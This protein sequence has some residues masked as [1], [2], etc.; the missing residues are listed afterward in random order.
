MNPWRELFARNETLVLFIHGQ[1]FFVLG[2]VILWQSRQHSRLDLARNLG[3]LGLFGIAHGLY[4]WGDV[5][6]PIQASYLSRTGVETLL[7][8]QAVLLA[9]SFA[10][11]FQFGVAALGDLHPNWRW[12][13][14]LPG[15][16]LVT[17]MSAFLWTSQVSR[18][19]ATEL[20]V[21]ANVWARYLLGVTGAI[22][23][24][25]GLRAQARQPMAVPEFSSLSRAFQVA[26][27]ALVSYAVLGGLVVPPAPFFPASMLNTDTVLNVLGVPV[28]VL[29]S[30]VGLVLVVSI[31]RGL[32]VFR[33]EADRRME[34]MEQTQ[35]LMVERERISRE[36]HDGAIQTVYTAGLIAESVRKRLPDADPLAVRLDSVVSALSHAIHDLRHLISN[37]EPKTTSSDLAAELR[38]L[39]EDSHVNWLIHVEVSLIPSDGALL[40]PNGANHVRAIVNEALS[41]I[42]RHARARHAWIV[43]E[44][45]NGELTITVAD[46]GDGVPAQHTVGFGLRNMRDRARLLGGTLRVDPRAPRGTQVI[47]TIPW[48]G[49]P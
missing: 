38:Q 19:S 13:E 20:I 33:M 31:A 21:S 45:S 3:W 14:T 40:L 12:I 10:M 29:R 37:L 5:F 1:V 43:A 26:S 11:L 46:D 4:V 35:I 49:T 27:L 17:W 34:E 24:A 8:V 42:A 7:M 36:L 32:E 15:L 28:Q 9:F 48:D 30:V 25:I 44:R 2:L 16:L 41:N 47:L 39:A 23:A 22:V 6:I 18:R